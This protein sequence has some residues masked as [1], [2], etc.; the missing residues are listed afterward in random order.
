MSL[1]PDQYPIFPLSTVLY[2]G[3]TLALRIFE[4]RYLAMV[5]DCT[6]DSRPFGVTLLLR[7][8]D[9]PD[10]S[11]AL[12]VG[13][14][15]SIVDFYT[16]PDGLL[17]IRSIGGRRFHVEQAHTRHDGLLIGQLTLWEDEACQ[18]L[19][20]EYSLLARLAQGLVENLIEGA[21]EP[22]KAQLD[23]ATWISFRLA[24]L[25][26][27]SPGE[28]QQLLELTEANERLQRIVDAL[29]RFRSDIDEPI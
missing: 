21:P 9:D 11:T 3:G 24:E 19:P 14:L 15:A 22:T 8:S 4:P 26:P 29:P 20:P 25:L 12:A 7:N 28:K 2:P 6:R 5:R 18:E 13:T 1:Q 16:L 10:S 23:D 27:F 17:G